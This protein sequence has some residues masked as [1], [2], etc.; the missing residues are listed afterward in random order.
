ML[1][2]IVFLCKVCPTFYIVKN[3]VMYTSDVNNMMFLRETN[4]S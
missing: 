1:D 3:R 2:L 4:K